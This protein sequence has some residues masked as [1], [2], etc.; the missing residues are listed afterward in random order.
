FPI[1]VRNLTRFVRLKEKN[2]AQ[3]FVRKNPHRNRSCVG[4]RNGDEAFPLRLKRCDIDEHTSARVSGFSNAKSQ[5]ITGNAQVFDGTT[6]NITV[7]R[8][9]AEGASMLAVIVGRNSLW[10]QHR[11]G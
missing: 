9:I 4:D 5:Y 3:S 2:L 8:D 7:R 10:I 6:Q 11:T 1:L